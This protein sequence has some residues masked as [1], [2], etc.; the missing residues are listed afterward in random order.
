[1][2]HANQKKYII[3][4]NDLIGYLERLSREKIIYG[5]VRKKDQVVFDR[6]TPYSPIQM[7][8]GMTMLSPSKFF[9]PMRETLFTT[10][11]E[12]RETENYFSLKSIEVL[13]DFFAADTVVVGVH[14]HDMSAIRILD[15]VFMSGDFA[16][17]MYMKR[18]ENTAIIVINQAH[19]WDT[20]FS[21]SM[22]TG[23]FLSSY[24]G[25]DIVLTM[26]G[27]N[28]FTE[29]VSEKGERLLHAVPLKEATSGDLAAR[30]SEEARVIS[31]FRKK[32]E[33]DALPGLVLNNQDHEI[34]KRIADDRCL[35]CTNCTMVCP[36]CFCYS[37][38]DRT[39]IDLKLTEKSRYKDS[40]QELY[41]SEVHGGNFRVT[42][43]ARL[44]Q[45]V[46]HKI[47]T[48]V[49]QFGCFGCVGCGRCMYWCPT[50]IDLVDIVNEI[51]TG[52]ST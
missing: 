4:S 5:P 13:A 27:D 43:Q 21:Y 12:T 8:Y 22:G 37:L 50:K 45:F 33:I 32:I 25:C 7:D 24:D 15:R 49:E 14:P 18:R 29:V 31:L 1:M 30:E 40:C 47:G 38:E 17:E 19:I 28:F 9:Y 44:R 20:C 52:I 11:N 34:W 3:R 51:A 2:T 16:D 10:K 48:W 39:S 26:L 23:P 35:G 6:I 41:F 36:T 42:R 46:T